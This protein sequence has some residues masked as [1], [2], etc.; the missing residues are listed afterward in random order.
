MGSG[1]QDSHVNNRK[2]EVDVDANK[3]AEARTCIL[4]MTIWY[5]LVG[6]KPHNV[7]NASILS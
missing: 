2:T 7:R 5:I 1:G 6:A 4:R 3:G